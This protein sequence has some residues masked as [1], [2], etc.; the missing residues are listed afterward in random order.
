MPSYS[1]KTCNFC[2]IK[3]TADNMVRAQK[4]SE[5]KIK[6]SV[7]TRD[8]LGTLVG[9]KTS[10]RSLNKAIF[11]G[12]G[13]TATRK[14]EVWSCYECQGLESPEEKT[15]RLIRE[16]E[17]KTERL[18]REK[19]Q[20]TQNKTNII[21]LKQLKQDTRVDD[22]EINTRIENYIELIAN[23]ELSKK[24]KDILISAANEMLKHSNKAKDALGNITYDSE[25]SELIIPDEVISLWKPIEPKNDIYFPMKNRNGGGFFGWLFSIAFVHLIKDLLVG[26]V[27]LLVSIGIYLV[28]L[29]LWKFFV[30][31]TETPSQDAK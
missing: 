13:R 3:N 24:D 18:I 5:V 10:Q 29:L 25:K 31:Q 19:E 2:G 8:V 4:T 6:N 15:E 28:L 27:S 14:S 7:T 30:Y 21:K 26:N 12:G 23:K 11:S 17:E 20:K 9:S 1:T 16:R 22:K